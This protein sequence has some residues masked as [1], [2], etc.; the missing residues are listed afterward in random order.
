MCG[1]VVRQFGP[2]VGFP[3]MRCHLSLGL[4]ASSV[5]ISAD[6]RC[7]VEVTPEAE[8]SFLAFWEAHK[9]LPLQG[10]NKMIAGMCPQ[11]CGLFIV[12]LT[13][14]LMLAGGVSGRR[15]ANESPNRNADDDARG[16]N[17]ARGEIHVLLVG[18]PGT[19]KSQFMK[20]IAALSPRA[21]TVGGR[22]SSAAGLTAAAVKDGGNW[23]LEAG[24][25][26]LADGGVCCIDE[27]DCVREADRAALHEAMEQQTCS[28]AKAGVVTTLHT[29]ASV[30]GTCNP[31]GNRRYDSRRPLAEQLNIGGPLLSRFDV[32]LLLID[33]L[34]P[35]EDEVV[36]N[37]ILSES[38]NAAA[39]M[40]KNRR[41]SRGYPELLTQINKRNDQNTTELAAGGGEGWTVE[42]LRQYL[43][44]I[45]T[46][47][48]PRLTPEAEAV[49]SG[50]YRL[51]R[52]AEGRH[53]ARTTLRMLESLVRLTQ[54]HAR[55]MARHEATLQDAVVVVALTEAS[56]AAEGEG[57]FRGAMNQVIPGIKLCAEGG[58][59]PDDPDGEYVVMENKVLA[60]LGLRGGDNNR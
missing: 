27:F 11:L 37:H 49:L 50:Y 48:Q 35:Q 1:V 39:A 38:T 33:R 26:V 18:D 2:H 30:F 54:A 60:A 55:L 23:S 44:W 5:S 19:G 25:L 4:L 6:R 34:D 42:V 20:Y 40:Q 24:A 43:Q 12:K 52:G 16:S 7:A 51:R 47:F 36:A 57:S 56:C 41:G 58:H 9:D 14:L 31:K 29:R 3:G 13:S 45:K 8:A 22:A 59:F 32:V 28:V 17:G 10:R 46:T 53:A 15:D 21:V